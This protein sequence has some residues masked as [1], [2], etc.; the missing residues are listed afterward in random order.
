MCEP[1]IAYDLSHCIRFKRNIN[2]SIVVLKTF[3]AYLRPDC[4]FVNIVVL[5]LKIINVCAQTR[6]VS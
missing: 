1:C 3:F 5:N 2:I 6:C 4:G